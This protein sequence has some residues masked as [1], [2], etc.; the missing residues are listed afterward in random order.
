MN[1]FFIFF[2]KFILLKFWLILS[3]LKFYWMFLF[4]I[5]FILNIVSFIKINGVFESKFNLLVY[6]IK[7]YSIEFQ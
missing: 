3:S 4:I 7:N 5:Y 6:D 2:F 1:Q